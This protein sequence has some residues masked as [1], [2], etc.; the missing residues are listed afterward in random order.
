M[1]FFVIYS[2]RS[3]SN[4]KQKKKKKKKRP[5]SRRFIEKNSQ[6]AVKIIINFKLK[7]ILDTPLLKKF[8][9]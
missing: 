7:G 8:K 9:S 1:Y 6:R 5:A 4:K 2:N 3:G